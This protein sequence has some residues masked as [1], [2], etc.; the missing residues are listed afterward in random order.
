MTPKEREQEDES[1]REGAGRLFA[2]AGRAR[3]MRRSRTPR[4]SLGK[5]RFVETPA[6]FEAIALPRPQKLLDFLFLVL[7]FEEGPLSVLTPTS[8]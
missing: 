4:S 5:A 6:H 2:A 3:C 1:S 7:L 8:L